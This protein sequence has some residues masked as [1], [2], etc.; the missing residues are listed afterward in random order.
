MP[1]DL[2]G[3]CSPSRATVVCEAFFPTAAVRE[4]AAEQQAEA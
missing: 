4:A 2:A 1:C 3:V